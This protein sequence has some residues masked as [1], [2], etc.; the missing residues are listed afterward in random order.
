[1]DVAERRR[2]AERAVSNDVADRT[3]VSPAG[4]TTER[5]Q[6]WRRAGRVLGRTH[7]H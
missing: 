7:L 4:R 2:I 6:L 5:R 1:M 3:G